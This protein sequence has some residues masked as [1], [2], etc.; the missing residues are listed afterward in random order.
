M[1]VIGLI[2]ESMAPLGAVGV[3]MIALALLFR[4]ADRAL[5]RRSTNRALSWRLVWYGGFLAVIV[6]AA[7]VL[8]SLIADHLTQQVWTQNEAVIQEITAPIADEGEQEFENRLWAAMEDLSDDQALA[9]NVY[10]RADALIGSYIAILAV[11]LFKLLLLP[12]V[13]L[14]ASYQAVRLAAR[15]D[16]M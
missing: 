8:S 15:G 2:A 13:V 4:R 9:S 10:H 5:G 3:G 11:F 14:G 12:A 7:F 1:V 6:P 16:L